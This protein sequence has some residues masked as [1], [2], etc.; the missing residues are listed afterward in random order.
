[1]KLGGREGRNLE[2]KYAWRAVTSWL[3]FLVHMVPMQ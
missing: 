1:M 3:K 2:K